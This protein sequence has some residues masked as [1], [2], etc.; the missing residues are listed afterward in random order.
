M[1]RKQLT[2]LFAENDQ[3][4][5]E[6][7]PTYLNRALL[8]VYPDRKPKKD[9]AESLIKAEAKLNSTQEYPLIVLDI[10]MVSD[11]PKEAETS[12]L[13]LVEQAR[14]SRPRSVILVLTWHSEEY[15]QSALDR[16][17]DILFSKTDLQFD[18]N[19]VDTLAD[20]LRRA[21]QKRKPT[22]LF[23]IDC[24]LVSSPQD[25]PLQADIEAI[26]EENIRNCISGMLKPQPTRITLEYVS[27][28]YSGARVMKASCSTS[29]ESG[30]DTDS[31]L[32]KF[33]RESELISR[34]RDRI[35]EFAK[36][37]DH[38]HVGY[39]PAPVQDSGGWWAIGSYYQRVGGSLFGFVTDPSETR[40]ADDVLKTLFLGA[41][42]AS[43]YM[44]HR[45][46]VPERPN[47]HIWKWFSLKRKSRVMLAAEQLEPLIR[48]KCTEVAEAFDARLI[49]GF[50][51]EAKRIGDLDEESVNI[52][53]SLDCLSHGDLHTGNVLLIGDNG[54][55]AIPR[56]IDPADVAY[57]PWGA[58][59]ARLC[60]DLIVT[61]VDHGAESYDWQHLDYWMAIVKGLAE[62]TE[63]NDISRIDQRICDALRFLRSNAC[64]IYGQAAPC[65]WEFRLMLAVEFLRSA[66]LLHLPMPKRALAMIAACTCLR[67]A[68]TQYRTLSKPKG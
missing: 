55:L 50:M 53:E 27:T 29:N 52:S 63:P 10:A 60:V 47:T 13:L 26:G 64:K 7:L 56:L 32:L 30:T 33:S 25:L 1:D 58:D 45:R 61:G 2:Y 42:L 19:A 18:A 68:E 4:D 44:D 17:A 37:P 54:G 46:S 66:Y 8:R 24:E 22:S 34:E 67:S 35:D 36:F 41:G 23:A 11:D 20:E 3:Q 57:L 65:D 39:L 51:S 48:E 40:N 62:N 28:G 43:T 21:F 12:G 49:S 6:R 9:A 15:G 31:Y 5:R 16:D 59:V 14:E 38:I